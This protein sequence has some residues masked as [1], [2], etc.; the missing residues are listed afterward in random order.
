M[1]PNKAETRGTDALLF[2]ICIVITVYRPSSFIDD[3]STKGT[4]NSCVG[5]MVRS[6]SRIQARKSH[7]SRLRLDNK[8]RGKPQG[9]QLCSKVF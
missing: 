3:S 9:S 8:L 5:F 7:A 2:E 6:I 4:V 1:S